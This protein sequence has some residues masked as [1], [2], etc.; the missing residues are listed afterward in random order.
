MPGGQA[1]Q[2]DGVGVDAADLG[3]A[4]RVV[5][6]VVV[7]A[8]DQLRQARSCRRRAGTP[9]RRGCPA[10]RRPAGPVPGVQPARRTARRSIDRRRDVTAGDE[11]MRGLGALRP[12]ARAPVPGGRSR[13]AGRVR[14][15]RRPRRG[16]PGSAARAAVRGQRHHRDD[17]GA[18]T[19]QGEDDELPAVGELD[20]DPVTAV[21]AEMSSSAAARASARATRSDRWAAC[22]RPR[23]HVCRIGRRRPAR[24]RG[25]RR[26]RQRPA[27]EYPATSSRPGTRLR[28]RA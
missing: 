17:A 15:S 26:P 23:R 25:E 14:R 9:R 4:P 11:H 2:V 10:G 12:P 7:G 18:Q 5:R 24:A 19:G 6:V 28:L 1:H 20:D 3:A 21:E 27:A 8:G 22:R 13:A 16:P